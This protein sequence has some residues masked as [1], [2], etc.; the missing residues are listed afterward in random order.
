MMMRRSKL[1]A[2]LLAYLAVGPVLAAGRPACCVRSSEARV[3]AHGCCAPRSGALASAAKGCCKKPVV[4][5]PETKVSDAGP[6]VLS[7]HPLELGA[8][9]LA[10]ATLPEAVSTRL[11][12]RAHHASEPDDSPPDLLARIRILLI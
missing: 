4:P 2:V 6:M 5:K 10:I 7:I 3:A 11:A 12:R 9:A 1:V 8:P